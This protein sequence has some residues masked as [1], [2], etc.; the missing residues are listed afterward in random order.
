MKMPTS[1]PQ[2]RMTLSLRSL[3]AQEA[4]PIQTVWAVL[5]ILPNKVL[6]WQEFMGGFLSHCLITFNVELEPLCLI[7]SEKHDMEDG[8][9]RRN[10]FVF[11]CL[12]LSFGKNLWT[13]NEMHWV[14]LCEC[15]VSVANCKGAPQHLNVMEKKAG[16]FYSEGILPIWKHTENNCKLGGIF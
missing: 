9:V 3:T 14:K 6:F 10:L 13:W 16:D 8:F 15:H 11:L 12:E 5:F 4:M 2:T 1:C 7:Y